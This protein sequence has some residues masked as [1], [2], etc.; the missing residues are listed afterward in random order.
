MLKKVA[1][2]V[3][4]FMLPV[5][6]FAQIGGTQPS[7]LPDTSNLGSAGGI[8]SLGRT[9]VNWLFGILLVLAVIF[10]VWAAFLYL[11]SGGDEEKTKKA[12]GMIIAAVIAIAIAILARAIVQF[13][14]SIFGVQTVIQ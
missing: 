10:I 5:L 4:L 14:G 9:I 7:T 11:T 1:V 12:R 8:Q 3:V 13:V 6:V 2:G